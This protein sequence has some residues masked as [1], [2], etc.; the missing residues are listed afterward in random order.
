MTFGEE[1]PV[2]FAARGQIG[3]VLGGATILGT[4]RDYLFYSGGGGTV[5][6]QPYQAL[7]VEIARIYGDKIG[8]MAFAAGTAEVRARVTSKIGVVGFADVGYVSPFDLGD[9]FGEW[10][11]GAGLGLRYATGF[12]PIRVD[13]ATPVKGSVD[14]GDGVQFY[15]GIGQAF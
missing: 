10:H 3:A 13:I 11:A 14:T 6:G 7:G 4:P 8:G 2:T 15:I 1:R 5:R 12:G 9:E